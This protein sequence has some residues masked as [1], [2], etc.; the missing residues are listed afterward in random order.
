MVAAT[1]DVAGDHGSSGSRRHR[2]FLQKEI[3]AL[4]IRRARRKRPRWLC[5][6]VGRWLFCRFQHLDM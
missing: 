6:D 1:L 5:L 4:A 2:R 3:A